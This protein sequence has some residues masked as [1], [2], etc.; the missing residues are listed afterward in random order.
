MNYEIY[1][2]L[3]VPIAVQ[4]YVIYVARRSSKTLY[5]APSFIWL[6][7]AELLANSLELSPAWW[8]EERG[9]GTRDAREARG[10]CP[11]GPQGRKL[12]SV[13]NCIHSLLLFAF[14]H[15]FT[16]TLVACLTS[17]RFALCDSSFPKII[18]S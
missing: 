8:F 12:D 9:V 4:Q 2:S 7:I 3:R 6:Q 1:L 14:H 18:V 16:C 15:A 5:C 13:I 17:S 10:Q 11:Y